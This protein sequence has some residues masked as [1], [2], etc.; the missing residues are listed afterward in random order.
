MAETAQP[1]QT[2]QTPSLLRAS[3]NLATFH[4]EHEKFYAAAPREQAVALQRYARTLQALAGR[5]STT[6]TASPA[7]LSAFE[8]AQDLNDFAAVQLAGVLFMEGAGEPAEIS[9]LKRDLG[10]VADDMLAAGNW[11][12]SAM[13]SAWDTAV[14][15]LDI[16]ELADLLGQRHRIIVNDWQAGQMSILAGCL[17]RRAGEIL[18]RVGFAPDAL[19]AD[20]SN[21][22]SAPRLLYSAAELIARAAD[23]LSDSAGL[24]GDNECR[25]RTFH[26]RVQRL[27]DQAAPPVPQDQSRAE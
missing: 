23:L 15:L 9:R 5:W 6:T 2:G 22:A 1:P 27:L 8:G 12:V 3:E 24:V 20:L 25:W 11:L 10:T 7:P 19:R 17:L 4:H 16:T 13:Q 18:D 21:T 26:T 14:A